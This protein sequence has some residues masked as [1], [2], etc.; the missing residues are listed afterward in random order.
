MIANFFAG[1]T[2]WLVTASWLWMFPILLLLFIIASYAVYGASQDRHHYGWASTIAIV[3]IAFFRIRYNI[4]WLTLLEYFAASIGIG[5]VYFL[6]KWVLEVKKYHGRVV[7]AF[8]PVTWPVDNLEIFT[9]DCAVGIKY[10]SKTDGP[11]SKERA[12][13]Y[14]TPKFSDYK[15]LASAW[16]IYWPFFLFSD[17]APYRIVEHILNVFGNLCQA[18]ANRL[19]QF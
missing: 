2:L 10:L 3:L 17:I 15:G 13:Q 7:T 9:Y 6:M 1:I 16:V 11:W 14:L 19:F 8:E 12:V 18:Y 5:I 4:P